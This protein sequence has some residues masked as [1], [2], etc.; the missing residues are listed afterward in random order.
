[1]KAMYE[2][3]SKRK[4]RLRLTFTYAVM[5]LTTLGLVVV[6]LFIAL[7]Y[8]Y[9]QFDGR[10]EQGGM[11]QFNSRPSGAEIQLDTAKLSNRTATRIT[12]TAGNNAVTVSRDGYK[13]WQ[14][15][16]TVK[17]GAVLWLNYVRLVPT[18]PK[19][20]T[21]ATYGS[22]ASAMASFDRSRFAVIEND[23]QPT[24]TFSRV[25]DTGVE[26]SSVAVPADK[27]T[28]SSTA[29]SDRF[30]LAGWDYVNKRVLVLHTYDADKA[31][32][33]LV[34]KDS[35]DPARNLST[36]F[37]I[38]IAEFQYD[39]TDSDVAYVLTMNHDI[40][41]LNLSTSTLSGPLVTNAS[42]LVVAYNGWIGYAT[43]A[44]SSGIRTVGY[45]SKDKLTA[46][47]VQT[48][49]NMSGR[50][51]SYTIASYY[52]ELYQLVVAG[53]SATVYRAELPSSDSMDTVK[54]KMIAKLSLAKDVAFAGFSPREQRFV[55][56]Q[57]GRDIVTY[58]LELSS[59]ATVAPSA[60]LNA[61]IGWL[62]DFHLLSTADGTVE[63]MDYDGT[64]MQTLA[65]NA[66]YAATLLA[67]NDKFF[68]YFTRDEAAGTV[69]LMRLSLT[70]E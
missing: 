69:R 36:E 63:F 30:S 60:A 42:S 37:G 64:N 43:Y 66:S 11:I 53:D 21:A 15:Q 52:N 40:R 41:R 59:I 28:V 27:I 46:K 49:T 6:A 9:N 45:V 22:I 62:D 67:G 55:Y 24:V 1:M 5:I 2:Y 17:P 58:D 32:Y 12:A 68:Y 65:R 25:H 18:D 19:I 10:F 39:P 31:E 23:T 33:L 26:H 16:A 38:S 35:G 50:S 61:K 57:N 8:R 4:L 13:P 34:S 7:G 56:I 48:F 3:D 20:E 70:T 14:K 29:G 47:T 44:D 54:S 51:L